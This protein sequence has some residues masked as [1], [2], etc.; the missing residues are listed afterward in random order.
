M[1]L[2]SRKKATHS[3]GSSLVNNFLEAYKKEKEATQ[4][5]DKEI[6]VPRDLGLLDS[7]AEMAVECLSLDVDQRPTMTE[8]A[9]RL[10]KLF[11]SR[12]L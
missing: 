8:V 10:L 1:E 6:A 5:F 2:I 4:L 7:L 3:D 12:E 9:E 11:R